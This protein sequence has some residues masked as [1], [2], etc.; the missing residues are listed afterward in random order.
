M[1]IGGGAAADS[2]VTKW[3][4]VGAGCVPVQ[5]AIT[6]TTYKNG[7]AALTTATSTTAV[8]V[9][10]PVQYLGWGDDPNRLN[11][12]CA[13]APGNGP[14]IH[15]STN[16]SLIQVDKTTAVETTIATVSC[17]NTTTP[18]VVSAPLFMPGSATVPY[19][20]TEPYWYYVE[21]VLNPR[22]GTTSGFGSQQTL[23]GVELSVASV[24]L[25]SPASHGS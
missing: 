22:F 4:S 10:C 13:S 15:G 25:G 14:T 5:S 8:V 3:A 23:Y 24:I 1:G 18:H 17:G 6:G 9:A 20:F 19:V 12:T 21:V 7:G 11:M 2:G 16:A